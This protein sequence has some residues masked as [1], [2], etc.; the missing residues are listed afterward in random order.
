MKKFTFALL[1]LCVNCLIYAQAPHVL[2]VFP[3]NLNLNASPEV[4][5]TIDFDVAIDPNTVNTSSLRVFGKWSGPTNGVFTLEND[6]KRIKFVPNEPFFAGEVIHLS[7]NKKLKSATGLALE[8]GYSWQFWVRTLAGSLQQNL[9]AQ[10]PVRL[11]SENWI[12]TYGAYAGDLNNDGWSD[13]TAVNEKS[14]DLRIFLNDGNGLYPS[15]SFPIIPMG[16]ASASPNEAGD[17]NNDGEIDLVVT[18]AHDNETRVFLGNGQGNLTNMT[19]YNTGS[20][21]RAVAVFDFEGD[22]DDDILTANRNGSD[23]SLLTNDGTGV[24]SLSNMNPTGNGESALAVADANNDGNWDIFLGFYGSKKIALLLGDGNGNLTLSAEKTVTGSPWQIAAGDFNGDGSADI[25]SANSTGNRTAVLFGDGL[26]GL[27][28]PIHLNTSNY[29]FPIAIDGG[30]LDGDGDLDLVTSNY[31]SNNY[32]VFENDGNGNFSMADNLAAAQN[33]SCAILHDRDNDGDLDITGT[34]ETA[35]AILLFQNTG[36]SNIVE[37][38]W[39]SNFSFSPNPLKGQEIEIR[40]SL[41]KSAD[42]KA[43]FYN[44]LGQNVGTTVDLGKQNQGD[45]STKLKVPVSSEKF[46]FLKIMN[47]KSIIAFEKIISAED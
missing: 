34:D 29:L 40:I 33:A 20:N 47:G 45:F 46:L 23:M 39:V 9:I 14:D 31:E 17:F 1:I 2:T 5:I 22:G 15:I 13:L 6:A 28:A 35:D 30:D 12:Q 7:L 42:L 4:A 38:Q 27:S 19:V 11:S 8:K 26:G 44:I 43:Q 24:F 41:K 37:N 32:T 16:T 21:T 3:A 25:A 10:I 36:M 18:T